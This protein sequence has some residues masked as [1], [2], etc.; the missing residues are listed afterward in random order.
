MTQAYDANG[1]LASIADW[2]GRTISFGND[3]DGNTT[4]IAYPDGTTVT[5]TYDLGDAMTGADAQA[6]SP[7]DLGAGLAA[8]SYQ[9]D[10]AEQVKSESDTGALNASVAYGY[11]S[12]DRMGSVT[13]GGGSPANEA[14]DPSGDPTTMANGGTQVF[15]GAG[16]LTSAQ[17]S[18]GGSETYGYNPTGDHQL[19]RHHR[20]CGHLYL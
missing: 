13:V 17:S 11:D 8:V 16:Q 6:G 9:L 15:N 7:G 18:A 3:L 19:Y 4:S 5:N 2:G 14:Y 10:N 12:A 20:L 1:D